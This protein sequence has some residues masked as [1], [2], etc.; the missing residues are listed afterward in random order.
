MEGPSETWVITTNA[1]ENVVYLFNEKFN[2]DLFIIHEDIYY[3]TPKARE[4]LQR[5][6][7]VRLSVHPGVQIRFRGLDSFF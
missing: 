2:M 3:L 4:I 6:P 7:S 5:P 1:H